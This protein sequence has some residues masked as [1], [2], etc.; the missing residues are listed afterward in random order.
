M[1]DAQNMKLT[2]RRNPIQCWWQQRGGTLWEL[3]SMISF[4]QSL[5]WALTSLDTFWCITPIYLVWEIF[6]LMQLNV[7]KDR[8]HL[9]YGLENK[10]QDLFQIPQKTLCVQS[11]PT[12]N[13]G[14]NSMLRNKQTK[15]LISAERHF[16]G[17]NVIIWK[18]YGCMK[19]ASLKLL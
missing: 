8:W 19:V 15:K 13:Y 3:T 7:W 4:G 11:Y 10:K 6:L 5:H 2:H 16:V 9:V 1:A 14:I 17:F 12:S 18:N